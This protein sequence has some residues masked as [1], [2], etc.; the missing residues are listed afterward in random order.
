M[1]RKS[2]S[3]ET[4]AEPAKTKKPKKTRWYHHLWQ[5][6]K[7][8]QR[9]D[10]HTVWIL[11]AIVVVVTTV[12]VVVGGLV[13]GMYWYWGLLGFTFGLVAAMVFLSRRVEVAAYSQIEGQPGATYAAL[14]TLRRGWLF[15]QEPTAVTPQQD[16]VFRCVGRAG[17]VLVSEGPPHRVGRLLEKER[18]RCARV[19]AGAPVTLVQMGNGEGQVP[20]RKLTRHLSKLKPAITKQEVAAVNKRLVAM[21]G[22]KLPV[23]KGVDPMRARPDRK[24]LRGR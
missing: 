12:F 4:S 11:A 9:Y 8:T 1:A 21:G 15:A 16:A 17:V 23:P 3:A 13:N 10:R 6:Y 18:Q 20:L 24:G 2:A 7:I 19:V 22:A 5:A 14:S